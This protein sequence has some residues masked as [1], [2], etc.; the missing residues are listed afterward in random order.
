M[1]VRWSPEAGND[2]VRIIEYIR[3]QNPDAALRMARNIYRTVATLKHQPRRGRAGRVN[4]TRELVLAPLP[5]VVV[6]RVLADAVEVARVL[7]GA[8][9]WP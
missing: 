4:G 9:R 6:Y 3:A 7:H 2:F 8:Q 5:Y 1:E